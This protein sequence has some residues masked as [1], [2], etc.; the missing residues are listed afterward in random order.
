M[1]GASASRR[2]LVCEEKISEVEM[3]YPTH[4][5]KRDGGG[6]GGEGF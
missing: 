3:S 4:A 5:G 1:N 6:G 2:S